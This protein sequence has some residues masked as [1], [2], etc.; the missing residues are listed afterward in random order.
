MKFVLWFNKFD[1][2]LEIFTVI[3]VQKYEF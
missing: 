3:E 2:F 1:T